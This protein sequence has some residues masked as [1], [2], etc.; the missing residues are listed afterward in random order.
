MG[1]ERGGRGTNVG[2]GVVGGEKNG[3]SGRDSIFMN[4]SECDG[5]VVQNICGTPV[6]YT[7]Y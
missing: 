3:K 1:R 4:Y 5:T 6:E 2:V 7:V